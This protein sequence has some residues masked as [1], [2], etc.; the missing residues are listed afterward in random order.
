MLL[1]PRQI[2]WL[3]ASAPKQRLWL[4]TVAAKL[5]RLSKG[6]DMTSAPLAPCAARCQP[7][8]ALP[9][10]RPRC[11]HDRGGILLKRQHRLQSVRSRAGHPAGAVADDQV[12]SAVPG[13]GRRHDALRDFHEGAPRFQAIHRYSTKPEPRVEEHAFPWHVFIPHHPCGWT[14]N[15]SHHLRNPGCR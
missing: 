3:A 14:N 8:P 12:H 4:C 6:V 15:M 9:A 10:L 7:L 13:P 11:Y 2:L 5:L 1:S